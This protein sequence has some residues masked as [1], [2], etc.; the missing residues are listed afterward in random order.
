MVRYDCLR[1]V[2]TNSKLETNHL[3]VQ[4]ISNPVLHRGFVSEPTKKLT[5]ICWF[6]SVGRAA[7]LWQFS[8][9]NTLY[10][11]Y[12]FKSHNCRQMSRSGVQ[13]RQPAPLKIFLQ[14]SWFLRISIV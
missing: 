9:S 8:I 14:F 10:K 7:H 3:N 4:G 2:L 5:Y 12:E 6:S 11:R 1:S 13:V